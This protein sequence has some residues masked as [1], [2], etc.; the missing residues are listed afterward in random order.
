MALVGK[1]AEAELREAK[2]ANEDAVVKDRI[3]KKYR[4]R[5]IDVPLRKRRTKI[6]A[7]LL[8]ASKKSGVRT[9]LIRELSEF[10]IVMERIDGKL[11][12]DLEHDSKLLKLAGIYLA[13]LHNSDIIHGDYTPA[14]LMVDSNGELFVIDFG[15]GSFSK[16]LEDK[17]VDILLMK[18][19]LGSK[20]Q[21][22][23]FLKGYEK[24]SKEFE[25]VMNQLAEVEKRGRYVVRAMQG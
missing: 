2:F 10:G 9:P 25:K 20:A 12:R 15:L 1:G 21:Y 14:N 8:S 17:A 19:A 22:G 6:E 13:R 18:K 23:Q 24:E 7:R 5:E 11:L 4:I 3:E 16:D